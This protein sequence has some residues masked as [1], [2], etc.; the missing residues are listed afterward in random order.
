M[1]TSYHMRNKRTNWLFGIIIIV[2]AL[3]FFFFPRSISN[4]FQ[5]YSIKEVTF[6]E[7][8]FSMWV[9]DTP[10][11][12]SLGLSGISKLNAHQ[13]MIFVFTEE[14][15]YPFWMKDMLIPLDIIWLNEQKEVVFVKEN[16]M[17]E[18]YPSSY[19]PDT[20][21]L[22]VIEVREGTIQ[23]LNIEIGDSFEL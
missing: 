7:N 17:P 8:M 12:R 11:K 10:V 20:N 19:I 16:A 1:V 21:A 14:S 6:E 9:A 22:Y 18:D 2:S 3:A 13:G 5:G 15:N 23:S 4:N